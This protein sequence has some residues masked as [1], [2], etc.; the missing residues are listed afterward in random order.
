MNRDNII[1]D[2]LAS[3]QNK[4]NDICQEMASIFSKYITN[5]MVK[6]ADGKTISLRTINSKDKLLEAFSIVSKEYQAIRDFKTYIDK[7]EQSEYLIFGYKWED[8]LSDF[9]IVYKKMEL[10]KKLAKIN[11][12]VCELEKFYSGER[13][14]ENSFNSLLNDIENI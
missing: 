9:Q 7:D 4:K 8:W 1:D 11:E 2:K 5:L 3:L 13:K 10:T 14:E 6:S 12:A